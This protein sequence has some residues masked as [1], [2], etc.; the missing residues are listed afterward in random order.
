MQ[1]NPPQSVY[2]K[3]AITYSS[4]VLMAEA[5][6]LALAA[7]ITHQLHLQHTNF[8]TDNQELVHIFNASDHTNPSDWRIK[9]YTL[10][11]H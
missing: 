2:V 5:A 8:L 3:A 4:S 9:R 10:T 1:V 6:A 11:I 7:T